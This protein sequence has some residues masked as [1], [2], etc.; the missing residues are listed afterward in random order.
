MV[1]RVHVVCCPISFSLLSFRSLSLSRSVSLASSVSLDDAYRTNTF[2]IDILP[3]G[4]S[5][6]SAL[7]IPYC[8]LTLRPG[9]SRPAVH[10]DS[11]P[12]HKHPDL[13]PSF[14]RDH[15][16]RSVCPLS[17]LVEHHNMRTSLANTP[18]SNLGHPT[19]TVLP[20]CHPSSHCSQYRR[21]VL[22]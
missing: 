19:H 11:P 20:S 8:L 1:L 21:V 12:R 16:S 15:T 13:D 2:F 3:I 9:S 22:L 17:H 5:P 18:S 6:P 14:D 7:S 10:P 4:I